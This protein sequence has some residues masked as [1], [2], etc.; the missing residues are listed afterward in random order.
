MSYV[1]F[2]KENSFLLKHQLHNFST[3][4]L[5]ENYFKDK[6][7]IINFFRYTGQLLIDDPCF[8]LIEESNIRKIYKIINDYRFSKTACKSL[9]EIE[10]NLIMKLNNLKQYK[11]EDLLNKYI[12]Q[13]K[14][15][16]MW[17]GEIEK[18]LPSL[19]AFD[20]NVIDSLKTKNAD[21]VNTNL[22]LSSSIYLMTEFPEFYSCNPEIISESIKKFNS[23]IA[24]DDKFISKKSKYLSKHM[25]KVLNRI[26]K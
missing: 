7:S 18:N 26:N 16:R 8:L 13:Q 4:E 1:K 22:F 14:I 11:S 17:R 20:Y 24:S 2:E 19:M 3:E 12:D 15:G 9:C 5:E 21:K 6:E 25:T 23:M 10:N